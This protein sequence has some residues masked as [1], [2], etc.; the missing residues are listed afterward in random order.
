MKDFLQKI[1]IKVLIIIALLFRLLISFFPPFEIDQIGWRAWS[2]R[3]VEVGPANFYSKEIFTD[4]PPGFLYVFGFIG[5]LK[6]LFFPNSPTNLEFDM[7]LKLPTNLADI[8]SGFIIF[9]LLKRKFTD[10]TSKL[11]FIFYVFNPALFFNTSIW[12][13]FDGSATLF[14]LLS[15][16]LI[17]V[18]KSPELS[19]ISFA[20]AWAIKPQALAFAPIFGMIML[21]QLNYK[22]WFTS[23]LA[24]AMTSLFLYWPFFPN[25]PILG[26]FE[27]NKAMTGIFKCTTCYAFNFWGMFGNW[28]DDQQ[29]LFQIT[30]LQWGIVLLFL[31]FIPILFLKPFKK[32]FQEPFVYITAAISIFS[33]FIFLTRMHE[34]YLFPMFPFLLLAALF[35]KSQR[36][37]IIYAFTSLI[38]FFNQYLAYGYY[39][40]ILPQKTDIFNPPL[41]LEILDNFKTLSAVNFIYFL[42]L[43]A[44]FALILMKQ[45]QKT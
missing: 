1:D 22:K 14:L 8:A 19:A 7:L 31:S 25:D 35:L 10:F 20:I 34:R 44:F 27:I 5:L 36:L 3:M 12:G 17:L 16:Y 18:K 6:N 9:L 42:F 43:L 40:Y 13:Q 37:L 15:T 2:M 11:G 24:F 32:R 29:K 21:T 38:Y 28:Q 30:Y 45:P 23:S 41:V 4:N 26:F 33:F 39:N